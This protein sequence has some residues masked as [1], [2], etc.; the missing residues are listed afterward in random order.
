[1]L[2]LIIVW[3]SL[4]E[5]SLWC[6]WIMDAYTSRA[7]CTHP[8]MEAPRLTPLVFI[9]IPFGKRKHQHPFLCITRRRNNFNANVK[10]SE[11]F[12]HAERTEQCL[13]RRERQLRL[14]SADT[15]VSL[16]A[17]ARTKNTSTVKFIRIY[18]VRATYLYVTMEEPLREARR[19]G[20]CLFLAAQLLSNTVAANICAHVW[21]R[22]RRCGKDLRVEVAPQTQPHASL[23][24]HL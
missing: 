10:A 20:V 9:K 16:Q 15:L 22:R 21:R 17:A 5:N 8:K 11:S 12:W 6:T 14:P 4:L 24:P 7:V 23:H 2:V 1:M 18:L 19:G 3:A 13:Q